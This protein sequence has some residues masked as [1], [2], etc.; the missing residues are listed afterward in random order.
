MKSKKPSWIGSSFSNNTSKGLSK[1]KLDDTLDLIGEDSLLT[2]D[3]LKKL[4]V[5]SCKMLG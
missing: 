2:E 1:V 4:Q 3:D 5:P